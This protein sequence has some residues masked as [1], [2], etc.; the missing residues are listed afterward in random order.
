MLEVHF[1]Q[2]PRP[3][4]TPYMDHPL[5]VADKLMDMMVKPDPKLAISALLH[6]SVEDQSNKLAEKYKGNDTNSTLSDEQMALEYIKVHFGTRVERTVAAL[7]NPD[8]DTQLAVLGINESHPDY[9]VRKNILYAQHV[10]EI[11]ENADAFIIKLMDFT[12]NAGDLMKLPEGSQKIKLM[13]KYGPVVSTMKDGLSKLSLP[14]KEEA[15]TTLGNKLEDTDRYISQ[16][17]TSK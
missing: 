17:I 1:D 12:S 13:R 5:T 11:S 9:R 10:A 16:H 15:K 4:G 2:N 7:S 3:D 6:D 14:I 8:F